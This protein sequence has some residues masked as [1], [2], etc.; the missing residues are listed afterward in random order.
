MVIISTSLKRTCL[1]INSA[2]TAK[3][4]L[5][6][7]TGLKF[8]KMLILF[9]SKIYSLGALFVSQ[10]IFD[11]SQIPSIRCLQKVPPNSC[12]SESDGSGRNLAT[13]GK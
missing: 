4:R 13:P 3:K 12:K 8:I 10:E 9:V 7:N 11:F 6:T 2:R 5:P 1:Y